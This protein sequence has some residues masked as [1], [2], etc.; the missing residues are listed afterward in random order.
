[1][2]ALCSLLLFC[3]S[4][5]GGRWFRP[6]FRSLYHV[7]R[8][9]S[10]GHLPFSWMIVSFFTHFV[11]SSLLGY[12]LGTPGNVCLIWGFLSRAWHRTHAQETPIVWM[13]EAGLYVLDKDN[14]GFEWRKVANTPE[15]PVIRAIKEIYPGNGIQKKWGRDTISI[16]W[17]EKQSNTQRYKIW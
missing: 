7:T 13:N 3:S 4:W 5:Y 12:E 2:R 11:M 6:H 1:M 10:S 9:S 17:I 14:G 8:C 16:G 15:A